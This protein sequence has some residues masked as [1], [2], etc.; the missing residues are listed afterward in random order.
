MRAVRITEFGGPEVLN[1]VDLPDPTPGDGEQLFE[2]S[3]AGINYADAHHRLSSDRPRSDPRPLSTPS[4]G[5][6]PQ[7]SA[8]AVPVLFVDGFP[9]TGVSAMTCSRRSRVGIE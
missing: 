2:V 9:D 4:A 1:V 5:G 3:T 6:T 7:G 8:R